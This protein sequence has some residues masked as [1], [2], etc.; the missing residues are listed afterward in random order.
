MITTDILNSILMGVDIGISLLQL[1]FFNYLI[2]GGWVTLLR[3]IGFFIDKTFISLLTKAFEYFELIIS[4]E[5]FAPKLIQGIT[6]NV[7]FFIAV[8]IL[9]KL[10]LRFI[11]YV[12]D[13]NLVSDDN[14]GTNAILRRAIVGMALIIF[15]PSIFTVIR[16]FQKAIIA[17]DVI[18]KIVMDKNTELKYEQ[19]K[20]K[21][22]VGR[23]IG[24]SVLQGFLNF[25]DSK[26]LSS[27]YK[28]QWNRAVESFD[29]ADID[30]N[31]GGSGY[32]TNYY[33]DYIPV[34]STVAL[35]YAL[36]LVIKYCFDVL[37]RFFKLTLLQIISPIVMVDY[38]FEGDQGTFKQWTT[39]VI[40]TFVMLFIRILSLSFV[41]MV[42]IHMQMSQQECIN[43]YVNT[44][45]SEKV[46]SDNRIACEN[47]LLYTD[48]DGDVDNL[49]RAAVIIA[50]L[51]FSMD[52]PKIL[53]GIFGLD[54][55][56]ESSVTGMIKK[57]GGVA[58]MVGLGGLALGGGLIGGAI[59]GVKSGLSV[60]ANWGSKNKALNNKKAGL[61]DDLA[62]GKITQAQFDTRMAKLDSASKR[63]NYTAASQM[64]ATT[65]GMAF[66]GLMAAAGRTE[67]GSAATS[68]YQSTRQQATSGAG[69]KE[70][71]GIMGAYNLSRDADDDKEEQNEKMQAEQ[72]ATAA[73]RE[74]Q[75]RQSSMQT[76]EMINQSIKLGVNQSIDSASVTGKAQALQDAGVDIEAGSVIGN[77]KTAN[78]TLS[79]IEDNTFYSGIESINNLESSGYIDSP[80]KISQTQDVEVETTQNVQHKTN[81]TGDTSAPQFDAS[82]LENTQ[83]Q[84][85]SRVENIDVET[86]QNIQHKT[87]VT[88]DTSAPQFDAGSIDGAKDQNITRSATTEIDT[89]M[90]VKQN[91]KP[92]NDKPMEVKTEFN[93]EHMDG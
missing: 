28:K 67:V 88:G 7:Y 16:D 8:F 84:N 51:A 49:L 68:G 52:L 4:K 6:D 54:L 72:A 66:G 89:L 75:M 78:A 92:T 25:D 73:Y 39:T 50:L 80:Q 19:V 31:A 60:G 81:V 79:K 42:A 3:S 91:I 48:A 57:V 82:S 22:P 12:M 1:S 11:K 15:I 70:A 18:N 14:V 30:I 61:K 24:F 21:A 33:Y 46:Q 69:V 45:D 17:D 58:K 43:T 90:D 47:S 37:V 65:R 53:G 9:F 86:T 44:E 63:N 41:I 23:I 62:S 34:I 35:G 56:Q 59:G 77:L 71:Q 13:P 87:N 55:E 36:W 74:H 40:A 26:F 5:L 64:A 76:E 29:P 32:S 83:S 93:P 27:V 85:I 20:Q 38:I 2:Q 10:A